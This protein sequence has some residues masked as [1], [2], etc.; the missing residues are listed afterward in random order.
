[1]WTSWRM[2]RRSV[3]SAA[4]WRRTFEPA[5]PLDIRLSCSWDG[6]TWTCS[7]S[8]N[9][10]VKTSPRLSRPMVSEGL[11]LKREQG[12]SPRSQFTE[13]RPTLLPVV[14]CHKTNFTQLS[15]STET[16]QNMLLYPTGHHVSPPDRI[17]WKTGSC[18]SYVFCL[19]P[20]SRWDGDQTAP[21]QKYEDSKEGNT[22]ADLR[23][24][25]SLEWSSDGGFVLMF[26]TCS[27]NQLLMLQSSFNVLLWH[28]LWF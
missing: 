13:V 4:S 15:D 6:S 11:K 9:A 28:V 3:S 24:G 23:L 1:M 8:T 19:V 22:E 2:R 26:S 21:D 27:C 12:S 25:Q 14:F 17:R 7:M 16:L 5:K 18:N 10:W 20:F